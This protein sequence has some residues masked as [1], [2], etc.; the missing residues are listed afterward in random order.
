[1]NLGKVWFLLILIFSSIRISNSILACFSINW[2]FTI[3]QLV[4]R[5]SSI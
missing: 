2:T 3:F 5:K 1:M 4:W